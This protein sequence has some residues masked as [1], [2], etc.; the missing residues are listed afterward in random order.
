MTTCIVTFGHVFY[1][2][3]TDHWC[4][5]LPDANCSSWP[6]FQDNCTDVKKSIFLPPPASNDS[7]YPHSSCDQWDLPDGYAFDPYVPPTDVDN[8]TVVPCESG[9]MY[10]TSQYKTTVNSEFD[11][12]C[13][14]KSLPSLAQS[15]YFGGF[16]VGSLVCGSLSDWIGRKKAIFVGLIFYVIG[17]L[18]TTFSVNIYMYMAFRFLAGFGNIGTYITIYVLV[19]ELIGKPYRTRT[20][21]TISM[22]Y[23]AGYFVLAP[24][25]MHVH[26]WRTLCLI[27]ASTTIPLF[28]PLLFVE[29]S[30]IWLVSKGKIQEAEAAIRRVAK[31]NGKTLPNVLFEKD[32]FEEA[33][34]GSNDSAVPP[35]VI[36]LFKTPNMAVKTIN[37]MY[38]WLVNSLV[39]YGLSQ[40][41]G[42][43]GM[44]E[45]WAF[46]LSGAVEIPGKLYA[47]F[48]LDL[49]GRKWNLAVL[50][51]IGGVACLATIFIPIGVWRTVVSMIGKFCI[52][53]TFGTI[54]LYSSEL[55]PTPVRTAGVGICSVS[56][57]IG[58]IISP[59]IL[60]LGSGPSSA[61][62]GS[63]AV[64]AGLLVFLL[65]ETKGQ[66]L[67]QTL[68]EG[69]EIGK[70]RCMKSGV[71]IDS[72]SLVEVNVI[73]KY[74][75]DS[76]ITL[77]IPAF[78]SKE[79]NQSDF[80][81]QYDADSTSVDS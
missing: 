38:N 51:L 69:E 18:V 30:V 1:A 28:V 31:M 40:S 35:S 27:M 66:K 75:K 11:L 74:I 33:K 70:C 42:D 55:F 63:S 44:N 62:F 13:E 3:E 37:M 54:Y 7:K 9:W 29:E 15:I 58:G 23:I 12:V 46:F 47:M 24:I 10:D 64:L 67:P 6:E 26:E 65:P 36:D 76:A 59:L 53:V 71:D 21:Q 34:T 22:C 14:K 68:E 52:S 72:E 43:L 60:L 17:S 77:S 50:E 4:S 57:R 16:L 49:F 2:A 48:G 8:F 5:V 80:S 19:L 78:D 79:E 20:A 39:Y 41:T 32:D 25:A 81:Q 45:Y 73:D 61:V 56:S